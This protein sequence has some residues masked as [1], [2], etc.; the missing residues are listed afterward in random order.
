DTL[1]QHSKNGLGFRGSEFPDKP[2]SYLKIITIGGSTTECFFISDDKVWSK[3]LE[4]SLAKDFGKVWVNNAGLNGHSTFGHR[5]LLEDIVAPLKPDYVF[6]LVG[7]ND[8]DRGDL[9]DF[10][11]K[12]LKGFHNAAAGSFS[13]DLL[14]FLANN[15]E[16]GNLLFNLS[17]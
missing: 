12:N 16:L 2:A 15:T 4:D 9:G 1:I 17:K 8:I 10:D 7:V 3:V 6:F 11:K 5:I 13:K 14:L